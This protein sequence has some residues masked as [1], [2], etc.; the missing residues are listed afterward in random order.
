M[1]FSSF[2]RLGDSS[3]KGDLAGYVEIEYGRKTQAS[4]ASTDDTSHLPV[5][6]VH[7]PLAIYALYHLGLVDWIL[8]EYLVFSMWFF[9]PIFSPP[10]TIY[11]VQPYRLTNSGK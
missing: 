5:L 11:S 6:F 2:R 7:P 8:I 9:Y 3:G 10:I 4:H 1:N